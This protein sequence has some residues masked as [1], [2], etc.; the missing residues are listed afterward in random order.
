MESEKETF[1]NVS[2][3]LRANFPWEKRKKEE[4]FIAL[5]VEEA[6]I[7]EDTKEL[8]KGK[9]IVLETFGKN[10][11]IWG[12]FDNQK[13]AEEEAKMLNVAEEVIDDIT[14]YAEKLIGKLSIEERE[15]L[16]RYTEGKIEI[17][18]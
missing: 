16:R 9:W 2:P 15:F 8:F 1:K 10:G 11:V 17:E 14:S 18:V 4:R 12:Y 7:R 3:S 6:P 5:P 13:M